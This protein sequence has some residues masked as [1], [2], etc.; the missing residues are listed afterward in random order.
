MKYCLNMIDLK[1]L[2]WPEAEEMVAQS[3]E[4]VCAYARDVI[5]GRWPKPKNIKDVPAVCLL[6]CQIRN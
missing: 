1:P 5:Q 4:W 2:N 3:P 6:I